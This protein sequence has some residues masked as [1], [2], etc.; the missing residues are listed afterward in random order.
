[1]ADCPAS[2]PIRLHYLI[3][4]T[5][6]RSS[7]WTNP[8]DRLVYILAPILETVSHDE[9]PIANHT[10]DSQIEGGDETMS[11]V[12]IE[13]SEENLACKNKLPPLEPSAG[14]NPDK[15]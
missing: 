14:S 10:V 7:T 5:V 15:L 2:G 4:P 8:H 9:R 3:Q 11:W 1:M 13:N 12:F 6:D